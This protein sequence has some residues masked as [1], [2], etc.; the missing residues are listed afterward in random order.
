[1]NDIEF[2]QNIVYLVIWPDRLLT[3]TYPCYYI[4]S[5]TNCHYD[6]INKKILYK[7]SRHKVHEYW[8]SSNSISFKEALSENKTVI[9][10][11]ESKFI[12]ECRGNEAYFHK[13]FGVV[14]NIKFFNRA[15][16]QVNNYDNPDYATYKHS[17]NEKEIRRLPR[18]HP[19]VISGEWVGVTKGHKMSEERI[20]FLRENFKGEKGSFYGRTHT[21]EAKKQNSE[22]NKIRLANNPE[23]KRRQ[24][25]QAT[26]TFKG[27]KQ[28][29][30]HIAKRADIHI[31][32]VTL[33]HKDTGETIRIK[34]DSERYLTIDRDIWKLPFQLREIITTTCIYC[35]TE[36][37][38]C[39]MFHRWHND[40][41][42]H[43]NGMIYHSCQYCGKIS[44]KKGNS[45]NHEKVCPMNPTYVQ[46]EFRCPHCN[47]TSNFMKGFSRFHFDN[48]TFNPMNDK[49]AYKCKYCD[50][51]F[52]TTIL[53][54]EHNKICK[55]VWPDLYCIHCNK[56]I[57]DEIM[58]QYF[59]GEKCKHAES[60]RICKY[61]G[62]ISKNPYLHKT[63]HDNNCKHKP[64]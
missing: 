3:E 6:E 18:D 25:E 41:C 48:C 55:K 14:A 54:R 62:E 17:I 36:G 19:L 5:K 2:N 64:I 63:H 30:E 46:K 12:Q 50:E 16:A 58:Y 33:Q 43:K 32:M 34:N 52:V 8:G 53:L 45:I 51:E 9:V 7:R 29:P 60:N 59:H 44:S 42:K 13:W 39:H 23:E 26:L 15:V 22:K 10:L 1:M 27:K 20:Q 21:E 31:G 57:H 24:S 11:S 35:G 28:T 38:D 37:E 40:N 56:T 4:G 49:E 61:C 47:S